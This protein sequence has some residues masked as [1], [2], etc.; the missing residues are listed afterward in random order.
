MSSDET[1]D[2]AGFNVV[3][4]RPLSESGEIRPEAPAEK[5]VLEVP[6]PPSAAAGIA[7]GFEELLEYLATPAFVYLGAL[8]NPETGRGEIDLRLAQ[9]Y[10]DQLHLF[11]K[12]TRNNL[13]REETALLEQLLAKLKIAFVQAAR[14]KK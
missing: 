6:L 2:K 9:A 7:P 14:Q 11:Q 5:P 12:K 3:D 8:P 1:R 13:S 4:R 10:I